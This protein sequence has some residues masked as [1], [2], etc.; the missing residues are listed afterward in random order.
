[1]AEK[2]KI[3][4]ES[5]NSPKQ[6]RRLLEAMDTEIDAL[7]TL[8]NELKADHATTRSNNLAMYNEMN[9]RTA[10]HTAMQAMTFTNAGLTTS[11]GSAAKMK[12]TNAIFYTIGGL[13]YTKA[14]GA[15]ALTAS[16]HDLDA[17][18]YGYY[19]ITVDASGSWA[20]TLGSTD[21]SASSATIPATPSSAAPVGILFGKGGTGGFDATTESID[22]ASGLTSVAYYDI[23]INPGDLNGSIANVTSAVPAT[24][25]ASSV[26]EQTTK[27]A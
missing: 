19:L 1:M 15:I 9:R 20:V 14:A 7:R 16:S 12:T 23:L 8:A 18:D 17:G 22:S 3:W 6:L 25:A 2:R 27:G 5:V 24:L 11:S 26:S 13:P 4:Y 21:S 10:S